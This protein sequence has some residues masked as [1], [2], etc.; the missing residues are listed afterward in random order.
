MSTILFIILVMLITFS[1]ILYSNVE[2]S[3]IDALIMGGIRLVLTM[4]FEFLAGHY[5]FGVSWE[6]PLLDYNILKG[7]MWIL[8]LLI[9]FIAPYL[10]I[11]IIDSFL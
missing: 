3:G 11:K 8:V 7:R 4:I 6:K 10:S 1:I 9:T 2:L 5:L